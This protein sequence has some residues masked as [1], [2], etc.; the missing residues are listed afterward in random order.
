MS[1]TMNYATEKPKFDEEVADKGE[2]RDM[3]T[4]WSARATNSTATGVRVFIDPMAL[5]HIVGTVMDFEVR[6][7]PCPKIIQFW[8]G[9]S[10][11]GGMIVEQ[12]TELASEFTFNNPNA[13]GKCGCGESF[14][15]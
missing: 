7:W 9:G 10:W 3:P 13:K 2:C 5:M 1:Y 14:N 11:S 8:F 12:E 15:V 6:G 4:A